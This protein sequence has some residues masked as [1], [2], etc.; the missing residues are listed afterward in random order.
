[1]PPDLLADLRAK[2]DLRTRV[3]LEFNHAVLTKQ[4]AGRVINS[5][6]AY[7]RFELCS[8]RF[9]FFWS[10]D[11]RRIFQ[12]AGRLI[13]YSAKAEALLIFSGHAG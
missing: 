11:R 1:M 6:K 8:Q 9:L 10:Q 13:K 5:A 4:L 2:V 12:L 3:E 7:N